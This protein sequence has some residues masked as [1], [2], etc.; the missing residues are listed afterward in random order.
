MHQM[1]EVSSQLL[2]HQMM[3]PFAFRLFTSNE[4]SERYAFDAPKCLTNNIKSPY[5]W[6]SKFSL[7]FLSLDV[8]I[9]GHPFLVFLIVSWLPYTCTSVFTVD[10]FPFP[11]GKSWNQQELNRSWKKDI[12]SNSTPT[13]LQTISTPLQLLWKKPSTPELTPTPCWSCPTLISV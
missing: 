11:S 7:F 1:L 13:P 9:Q 5:Q 10:F 8:M 2:L 6:L 4:K 3:N 12:N